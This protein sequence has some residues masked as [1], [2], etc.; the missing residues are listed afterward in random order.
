MDRALAAPSRSARRL[1]GAVPRAID[2][3]WNR[4]VAAWSSAFSRT[5]ARDCK[6]RSEHRNHG[7]VLFVRLRSKARY[8]VPTVGGQP[9]P[10]RQRICTN[11]A[12]FASISQNGCG[13]VGDLKEKWITLSRRE[14]CRL[15]ASISTWSSG[16][17]SAG[18]SCASP[19]KLTVAATASSCRV[20]GSMT[21]RRQLL[22]FL[23]TARARQLKPLDCLVWLSIQVARS[24][25][26]VS[27]L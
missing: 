26:T 13:R 17:M 8:T 3:N 24:A 12:D 4:L 27:D 11:P 1:P 15:S 20:P 23:R 25:P 7:S 19:K 6:L 22:T 14:N 16:K 18:D 21:L 2:R 10:R 5:R 9:S